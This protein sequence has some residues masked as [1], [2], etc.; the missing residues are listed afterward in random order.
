MEKLG[1]KIE[2]LEEEMAYSGEYDEHNAMVRLQVGNGGQ[3][4]EDF[5]AMLARMYTRWAEN[6]NLKVEVAEKSETDY[7]LRSVVME[8]HGEKAYGKLKSEHGVHRLIRMSPFNAKGLRQT[9]FARVE[10]LPVIETDE[11]LEIA[12]SDLRVDVFRS[13]G[14]GGQSVN[15]TDSAV[16]ITFL[17]LNLTVTCQNEKSQQ[18][19]KES[20]MKVLMGKLIQ[21]QL[22]T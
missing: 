7:G 20:A 3:D 11:D 8:M 21:S 2:V 9:S 4:A 22:F 18:Q 17:P 15:T 16:R 1:K 5:T 19:N 12:E 10:V 13:S 6:E 14:P